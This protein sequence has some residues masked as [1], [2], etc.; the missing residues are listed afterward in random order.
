MNKNYPSKQDNL[1][2]FQLS[3]Y[4]LPIVG[5]VPSL[6]SLFSGQSNLQQKKVSRTSI[7]LMLIWLFLYISLWL[8]SNITT[9]LLSLRLLYLNGLLTTG[10]FLSCLSLAIA[11]WQGKTPNLPWLNFFGKTKV[12][13][14][15]L[16][17]QQK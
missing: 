15:E 4:M 16:D 9:E 7:N 2:K 3:L 5:I 14:N 1:D 17:N 11:I 13:K 10:Y 6:W 12:V 8:G